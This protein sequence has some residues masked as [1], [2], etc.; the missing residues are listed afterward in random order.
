[1]AETPKGFVPDSTD[2][3]PEGF[4]PDVVVKAHTRSQPG[5][6]KRLAQEQSKNLPAYGAALG[7]ALGAPALAAGQAEIP[8][9]GAML[10]A[11]GGKALE[12]ALAGPL[13]LEG[14]KS[15][16]DAY[17]QQGNAAALQGAL[18][19]GPGIALQGASK[20]AQYF[21]KSQMSKALSPAKGI[22]KNF[23]G[24][25]QNA[26]E[27]RVTVSPA[28]QAAAERV[29]KAATDQV[30]GLLRAATNRGESIDIEK[31]AAPAIADIERK[32]G[33][34]SPMERADIIQKVQDRADELLLAS[35]QGVSKR[36]SRLMSPMMADELRKSAQNSAQA[37]LR[38]EAGTGVP[39]NAMPDLDKLILQ[40]ASRAVKDLSGVRA[41]RGA[42]KKAIGVARALYESEARPNPPAVGLGLGPVKVGVSLPPSAASRVAVGANDIASALQN[43]LT[44]TVITNLLRTL[45]QGGQALQQ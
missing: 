25:V 17:I 32:M 9:G 10:G 15:L 42:E 14:P 18:E 27:Q 6:L 34:L 24:V 21:A 4:V 11:A 39:Q 2:E 41:A 5:F 19:A 37:E 40:G 7:A 16:A 23:P 3:T 36:S 38:R 33:R 45:F 22:V 35:V 26:L 29:R 43:P 44:S 28:G 13:G 20:V 8:V 31:V 30:V 12:Q 1:M